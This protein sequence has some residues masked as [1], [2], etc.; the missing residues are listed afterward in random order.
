MFPDEDQRQ[1]FSVEDHGEPECSTRNKSPDISAQKHPS[2]GEKL[3]PVGLL[4][5]KLVTHFPAQK[6]KR[7]QVRLL[8]KCGSASNVT[9]DQEVASQILFS[10]STRIPRPPLKLVE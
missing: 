8:S 3:G 5:C 6:L 2:Q 10:L 7:A 9:S 4:G 1:L